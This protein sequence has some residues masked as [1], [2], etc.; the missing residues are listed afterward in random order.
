[1]NSQKNLFVLVLCYTV[2][3]LKENKVLMSLELCGCGLDPKELCEVFS[4]VGTTMTSLDL[5]EN[6]F[7]DHSTTS[8]GKILFKFID[9]APG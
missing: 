1:M 6:K 5:S 3:M 4:A 8:L 9:V 7:D 2:K